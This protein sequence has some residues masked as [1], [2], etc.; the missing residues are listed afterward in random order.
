MRN[1]RGEVFAVATREVDCGTLY[2]VSGWFPPPQ[3]RPVSEE[4]ATQRALGF[5]RD[6]FECGSGLVLE[7]AG[8]ELFGD[9]QQVFALEGG[10]MAARYLEELDLGHYGTPAGI[11]VAERH[12]AWPEEVGRAAIGTGDIGFGGLMIDEADVDAGGFGGGD[13]DAVGGGAR[14][15]DAKCPADDPKRLGGE[16]AGLPGDGNGGGEGCKMALPDGTAKEDALAPFK[17]GA[18]F[19]VA[20]SREETDKAIEP[21]EF[22]V[23]TVDGDENE[24]GNGLAG[25]LELACHLEGDEA[26]VA[27]AAKGVGALG[28]DL[29]DEFDAGGGH[30]LDGMRGDVVY[31]VGIDSVEGTV[32]AEVAGHFHAIET[33]FD[34]IAVQE[35]KGRE[36]A[37]GLDGDDGGMDAGLGMP[38]FDSKLADGGILKD[39][40]GG[41][42]DAGSFLGFDEHADGEE[43]IAAEFE[44]IVGDG[45][46]AAIEDVLPDIG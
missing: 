32:R 3:D 35:E 5:R 29:A 23:E 45:D 22:G 21:G 38:G 41:D 8:A 10:E 39:E 14:P 25:G 43:G 1:H 16:P 46:G 37:G 30:F 7:E 31:A 28:M 19:A 24:A 26:A 36:A 6:G 20:R 42:V 15:K 27:E 13:V 18:E 11:R 33:A 44:E 9:Y 12:I 4:V 17:K 40:A 34:E 2:E